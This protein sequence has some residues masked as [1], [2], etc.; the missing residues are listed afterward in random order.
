MNPWCFLGHVSIFV[1][2]ESLAH[3]AHVLLNIVNLNV[4]LL[5]KLAVVCLN[6]RINTL[7]CGVL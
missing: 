6:V 5:V 2:F 1:S 7:G 4:L 3:A